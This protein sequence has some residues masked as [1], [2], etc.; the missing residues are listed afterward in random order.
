MKQ[1]KTICV[2]NY[3]AKGHSVPLRI[4]ELPIAANKTLQYLS[5]V[6]KSALPTILALPGAHVK[7]KQQRLDENVGNMCKDVPNTQVAQVDLA[8][9]W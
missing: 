3:L 6:V 2:Y 4:H 1:T 7:L 8:I 5:W 9:P